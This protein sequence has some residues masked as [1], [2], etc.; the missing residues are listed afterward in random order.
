MKTARRAK[1]GK[2]K[3]APRRAAKAAASGV[4]PGKSRPRPEYGSK[5]SRSNPWQAFLQPRKLG[6]KDEEGRQIT[7]Y[8]ILPD[9]VRPIVDAIKREGITETTA[10]YERFAEVTGFTGSPASAWRIYSSASGLHLGITLV[11]RVLPVISSDD[12]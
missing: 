9:I 1:T 12:C 11:Q 10:V 6:V 7:T 5:P 8:G 2:K 4:K 3:T